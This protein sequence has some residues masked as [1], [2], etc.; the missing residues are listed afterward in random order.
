IWRVMDYTDDHLSTASPMRPFY[1]AAIGLVD[2]VVVPSPYLSIDMSSRFGGGINVIEDA[3][4]YALRVPK[5]RRAD[6]IP[7]LLWFG[8]ASN[9]DSLVDGLGR[10]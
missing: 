7:S 8:H 1:S 3:V 2:E 4:E 5:R 9:V 10:V 6:P